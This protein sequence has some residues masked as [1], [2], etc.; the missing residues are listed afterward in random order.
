[1][2]LS[3]K[4]V[5]ACYQFHRHYSTLVKGLVVARYELTIASRIADV[6]KC[7]I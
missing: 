6:I 2:S 7:D 5:Y 4:I 3:C 1:M